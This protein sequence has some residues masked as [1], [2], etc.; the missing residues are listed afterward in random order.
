[1]YKNRRDVTQ[2]DAIY[3]VKIKKLVA[4]PKE[5]PM[6]T[7]GLGSLPKDRTQT[8]RSYDLGLEG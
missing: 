2:I 3:S 6:A 5:Q 1:M 8:V 4:E 7:D